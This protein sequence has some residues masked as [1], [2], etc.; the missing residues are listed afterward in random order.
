MFR[1][2]AKPSI[3]QLK[4]LHKESQRLNTAHKT[5][6]QIAKFTEIGCKGQV[7]VMR[8][9]V[10][11]VRLCTGRTAYRE[12][13]GMTTAPKGVRDQRHAPAAL[14][15]RERPGTH[16]TGGWVGPRAGLDRCG[17]SCSPWILSPDRPAH[18]QSLYRLS[19][20]AHTNQ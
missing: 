4:K 3:R 14:C 1:L 18:S 20:L 6:F 2:L 8:T 7:K 10:Q 12:S 17:K 19:Y 13:R 11:A 15:L 16:C 5:I 9:L